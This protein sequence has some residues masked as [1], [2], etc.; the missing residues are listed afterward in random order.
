[1]LQPYK[2]PKEAS[3][4]EIAQWRNN[5]GAFAIIYEVNKKKF[6][7]PLVGIYSQVQLIAYVINDDIKL[8]QQHSI[9]QLEKFVESCNKMDVVAPVLLI[10]NA[11]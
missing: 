1:M 2:L 11:E 6:F 5:E 9:N 3:N 10:I 8:L 7:I 4:F